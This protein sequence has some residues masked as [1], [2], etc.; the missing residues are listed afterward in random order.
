VIPGTDVHINRSAPPDKRSYRV[1]FSLFRA[2]APDH[3]PQ[4]DLHG[5]IEALRDG[6]TGMHFNDPEF[7]NSPLIRLHVLADLE[8]RRLVS[9]TLEW[10]NRVPTADPA[11]SLRSA[12]VA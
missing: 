1:D 4:A 10:L 3:Q 6:L 2:L 5:T 8:R 12:P 7:R 9:P 11:L